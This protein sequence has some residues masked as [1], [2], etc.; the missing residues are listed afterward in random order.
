VQNENA[1]I[2]IKKIVSAML[3]DRLFLEQRAACTDQIQSDH[4]FENLKLS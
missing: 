2:F 3:A 4:N 1:C